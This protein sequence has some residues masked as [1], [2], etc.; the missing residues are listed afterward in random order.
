MSLSLLVFYG[1][2]RENRAG[3][4]F[5]TYCIDRLRARGHEVELIDA[6]EVGL[7]ML[8]KRYMDY[9]PGEVPQNMEALAEKLR[10]ADGFVFVAGEYNWGMQPGLKNLIDHYGNK[11]LARRPAAIV[12]Y[13]A[14]RMAGARS[15]SIWHGTLSSLGMAVVPSTVTVGTIT[16]TLD[17]AGAPIGDGGAALDRAFPAFMDEL[18]WWAE[19]V[20]ARRGNL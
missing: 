15:N 5:A 16:A 17:E 12:S 8:D 7:P 14:G 6:R 18:E 20:K 10:N 1:S 9:A 4:R 11:E 3:I 13:S 2:Y 19:A